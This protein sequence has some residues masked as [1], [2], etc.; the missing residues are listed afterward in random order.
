LVEHG[1][2]YPVVQNLVRRKAELEADLTSRKEK[3]SKSFEKCLGLRHTGKKKGDTVH[4]GDRKKKRTNESQRQP[5]RERRGGQR[6]D[7]AEE[8]RGET[9]T[10]SEKRGV[11]KKRSET[12]R[13]M[14]GKE[15]RLDRTGQ[16]QNGG[17][18]QR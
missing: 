5:E 14:K 18:K 8:G 13:G 12:G 7:K 4:S 6:G 16:C 2:D 9:A 15:K 3:R 10:L 17:N 11:R 1:G